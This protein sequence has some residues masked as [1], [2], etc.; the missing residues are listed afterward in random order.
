M[1]HLRVTLTIE[2]RAYYFNTRRL[3]YKTFI[4]PHL[5]YNKDG[6]YV[7]N[8]DNNGYNNRPENLKLVTKR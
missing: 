8:T 2:N 1:I 6:L 3:I 7:I 5:D 4:D